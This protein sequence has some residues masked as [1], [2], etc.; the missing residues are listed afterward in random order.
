MI[1]EYDKGYPIRDDYEES[2]EESA[3]LNAFAKYQ[4]NNPYRS[5]TIKINFFVLVLNVIKY[6]KDKYGKPGISRKDLPFI[7]TW[8]NNDYVSLAEKIYKFREKFGYNVSKEILYEYA[9]SHLDEKS[10]NNLIIP[11][12]KEFLEEKSKDYKQVKILVETPDETVRKLRLTR[13]IS[14]RGGG[15]FIDINSLEKEKI[16]YVINTYSENIDFQNDR[17]IYFEYM[18]KVDEKL[19]FES[20]I[21]ETQHEISIK[22]KT[23]V[24]WANKKD[25]EFLKKEIKN[26]SNSNNSTK[27]ELLKFIRETVRLEFLSAVILKKA[28]PHVKVK[29]NYKI[30]DQGIPFNTASGSNKNNVGADID[31]LEDKIHAIV[32]PSLAN[33]RSFQVEHELPSIRKHV[34]ASNEIDDKEKIN[35]WF[36][37]FLAPRI[38]PEV[39]NQTPLIR[40][41]NDV[42]IYAW[43]I[44]DFVEFSKSVKSI[45]DYK[46]IRDYAKPSKL[47]R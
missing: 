15:Y 10:D 30:D 43:K 25:W 31:V 20:N 2:Y 36:A 1:K 33:S 40:A 35:D 5:N 17:D 13:L 24:D 38:D 27:D 23:L 16:E 47:K 46:I 8:P 28:L 37:I 29:P 42:E 26:C 9:M 3:F 45:N 22:E 7:V 6:L 19:L 39:G 32:E 34:L 41:I 12:S 4:I 14:L 21:E 44:D 18:G 11:A